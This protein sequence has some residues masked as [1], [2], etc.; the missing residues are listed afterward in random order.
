[1]ANFKN[2]EEY[3]NSIYSLTKKYQKKYGFKIGTGIHDTW[4]NEAD[5]FKHTFMQADLALKYGVVLSGLAGHYHEFQP[6]NPI[7]EKNMDLWNN[8]QGRRIAIQIKK[9]YGNKLNKMSKSQIDDI[10]AEKVMQKM[11]KGELITNPADK[12]KFTGFAADL[13]DVKLTTYEDE[14]GTKLIYHNNGN[15]ITPKYLNSLSSKNRLI[16]KSEINLDNVDDSELIDRIVEQ[17]LNNESYSKKELDEALKLG[18]LIYV[19]SYTRS[20]G[21]EVSGYYRR[22]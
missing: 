8:K 15:E 18:G 4:N 20:D 2:I 17:S 21:T 22:P 3:N 13:D 12:R 19:D 11:R 14:K 7:E 16:Y 5:A 1:M 6:N 9:E 10:I